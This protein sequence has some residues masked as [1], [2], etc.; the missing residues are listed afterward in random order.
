M[1]ALDS[2]HLGM[3]RALPQPVA[4]GIDRTFLAAGQHFNPPIGQI[5]DISRYTQRPGFVRSG[6]AKANPLD[7]TGYIAM[8]ADFHRA[9]PNI[10]PLRPLL[11]PSGGH[12]TQHSVLRGL[13]ARLDGLV[14]GIQRVAA[15]I[16]IG[17]GFQIHLRILQQALRL[18][19]GIGRVLDRAG[20]L[21]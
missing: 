17:T 19:Q 9:S 11:H 18:L 20:G 8:Q 7:T 15:G 21:G 13:L 16:V 6:V 2:A 4:Q 1:F 3:G 10:G 12:R 14:A 5:A